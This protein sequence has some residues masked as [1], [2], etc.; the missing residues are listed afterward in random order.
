MAQVCKCNNG[1]TVTRGV[2]PPADCSSSRTT[3]CEGCCDGGVLVTGGGT[4]GTNRGP[5]GQELSFRS[6]D[7]TKQGSRNI[8]Q[9]VFGYLAVGLTAFIVGYSIMKGKKKAN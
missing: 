3:G 6:F 8:G 2:S 5:R 9:M 7:G 1:T 4:R